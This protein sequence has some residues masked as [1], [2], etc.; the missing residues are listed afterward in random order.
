MDFTE[1][2]EE[3]AEDFTEVRLEH[4]GGTLLIPRA[5]VD[6]EYLSVDMFPDDCDADTAYTV[7]G[8]AAGLQKL[9]TFEWK[10]EKA[11]PF[12][13]PIEL[14]R[15]GD[16]AYATMPPD[17]IVEQPWEAFVGIDNPDSAE[18]LDA[19]LFDLL[20]DNGETYGIELLSSLPTAITSD[21]VGKEA[22][23]AAIHLYLDWDEMR[24]VGAWKEAA[25]LLPSMLMDA[26]DLADAARALASADS[27][28]NRDRFMA[29]YVEVA[30]QAA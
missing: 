3:L 26:S 2:A 13:L 11:K 21:V 12:S 9:I 24:T 28:G 14:M 4:A 29:A 20:W 19:L 7:I 25:S 16:R 23:R 30:F 6:L 22:V 15:F 17:P 1:F 27:E 18:I 10:E 5:P 8:P